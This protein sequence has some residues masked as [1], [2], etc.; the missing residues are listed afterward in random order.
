MGTTIQTKTNDVAVLRQDFVD[1]DQLQGLDQ[2][3]GNQEQVERVVV[4]QL[5][6]RHTSRMPCA[7]EIRRASPSL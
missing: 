2:C 7:D 3:L 1:S 5:K 6:L 4:V